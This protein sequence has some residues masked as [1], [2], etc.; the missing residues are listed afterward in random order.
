V[1]LNNFFFDIN[2]Q[3]Y[4]NQT[5]QWFQ[6]FWNQNIS[7]FDYLYSM[8]LILNGIKTDL[9]IPVLWSLAVEMKASI[10]IPIIVIFFNFFTDNNKIIFYISILMFV[11][12]IAFNNNIMIGKF[13]LIF[14][15]GILLSKYLYKILELELS[16]LLMSFLFLVT[17]TAP[18]VIFPYFNIDKNDFLNDMVQSFAA[19]IL[20]VVFIKH[21]KLKFF[22]NFVFNN[23]GKV[24]YSFYLWHFPI[25]IFLSSF[26]FDNILYFTLL[27]ILLSLVL[28]N[29][30]FFF[31]EKKF[32]NYSKKI[33]GFIN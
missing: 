2:T 17:Y 31:I 5:S 15:F 19:V 3:S 10:I 16:S 7:F 14:Y 11:S 33:Q 18:Y 9:T 30:S 23:I 20:L 13:I 26:Y 21:R 24:S 28:S 4:H 6:S 22:K 27:S 29:L 25:I 32:M 8:S 1:I 12:V